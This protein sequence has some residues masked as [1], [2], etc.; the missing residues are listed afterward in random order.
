MSMVTRSTCYFQALYFAISGCWP[1]I[2]IASFQAV[3]GAKT[4]HLMTGSESDHWLVNTVGLLVACIGLALFLAAWNQRITPE[5]VVIGMASAI[6]LAAIDF[7]YVARE[8]IAQIY[9]AD[10][11][12]EVL[13]VGGWLVGLWRDSR[14]ANQ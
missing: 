3:T 10:A 6:S 2:D 5:I 13:I 8:T 14:R 9:L 1:L 11:A 4:D 12:L 7:I